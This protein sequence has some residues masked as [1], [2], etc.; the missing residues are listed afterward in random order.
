MSGV[1]HPELYLNT[2]EDPLVS[3]IVQ[4]ALAISVEVES[5]ATACTPRYQSAFNMAVL[6]TDSL[7][8]IVFK[9]VVVPAANCVELICASWKVNSLLELL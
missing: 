1:P 3:E 7:F 4:V 8:S 6:V 2:V 5:R 9:T